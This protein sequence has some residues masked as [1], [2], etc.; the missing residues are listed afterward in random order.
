M[1]DAGL[2]QVRVQPA[3][4]KLAHVVT[5][6]PLAGVTVVNKVG[7]QGGCSAWAH[8]AEAPRAD[9]RSEP[10]AQATRAATTVAVARLTPVVHHLGPPGQAAERTGGRYGDTRARPVS[11]PAFSGAAQPELVV[12]GQW[13]QGCGSRPITLLAPARHNVAVHA[14]AGMWSDVGGSLHGRVLAVDLSTRNAEHKRLPLFAADGELMLP[15]ATHISEPLPLVVREMNKSSNNL[16]ARHLMLSL[17][18]GFPVKSASIEGA[19]ASVQAWLKRQGLQD[20]DITLDNGSGLSRGERGKPRALA[21]LLVN[22]WASPVS[23]HFVESLPVAGVDG[24][25]AHRM[26]QGAA[27]GRAFLKT[28]TLND[29]R[30]LAGYVQG[31]SGRFYAVAA[32]VNHLHAAQAT[33]ALDAV[34]EWLAKNG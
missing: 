13:G 34:I 33:P 23:R 22:A 26:V 28:G 32:I 9:T 29:T 12:Q 8:W 7:M 16:T 10:R 17:T 4:G 11:V 3:R 2:M 27:T 1:V 25:L 19:Q 21:Q 24:T 31:V 18:K 6:P 15:W 20:G 5:E 14:M 30:A